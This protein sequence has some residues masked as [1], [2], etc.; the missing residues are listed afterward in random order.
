[1]DNYPYMGTETQSSNSVETYEEPEDD[2][3]V[4][5]HNTFEKSLDHS[6]DKLEKTAEEVVEIDIVKKNVVEL[7][8]TLNANAPEFK[9]GSFRATSNLFAPAQISSNATTSMSLNPGAAAFVPERK[10][11]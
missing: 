11:C 2:A 3:F 10:G 4:E 9:P 5:E 1:L 8:N 7:I 6:S